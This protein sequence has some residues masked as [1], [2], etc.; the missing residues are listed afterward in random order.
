MK[1]EIPKGTVSRETEHH[2][3]YELHSVGWHAADEALVE[4]IN[5]EIERLERQAA[6]LRKLRDAVF[7][8]V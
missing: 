6:T 8:V 5:R 4:P 2:L 3:R 1:A 7:G